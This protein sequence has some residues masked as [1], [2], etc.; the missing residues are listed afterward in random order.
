MRQRCLPLLSILLVLFGAASLAHADI[1]RWLDAKGNVNV[2][3]LP[4]PTV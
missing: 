1:Y 3:N 2:S 4:P